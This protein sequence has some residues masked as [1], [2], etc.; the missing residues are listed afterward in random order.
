MGFQWRFPSEP[1]E[2]KAT[3]RPSQ[4]DPELRR[5]LE[6]LRQIR[7]K[8]QRLLQERRESLNTWFGPRS[9]KQLGLFFAGAGFLLCTVAI[10]RRAV[11]RKQLAAR[12]KFFAPSLYNK[13]QPRVD[14]KGKTTEQFDPEAE[15][16][17]IAAQA[18]GLATLNVF[19]FAVMMTGG[20]SWALD[21]SGMDD[22]R[23]LARRKIQLEDGEVDPNGEKEIEEWMSSMLL[24]NNDTNAQDTAT[25]GT[26]DSGA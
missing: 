20:L 9:I 2:G 15:G 3:S 14:A 17:L 12:P 23:V 11:V 25:D 18:L 1:A 8:E 24:P 4:D 10:T 19:S 16:G 21:I 6:Q 5:Q 26:S 7:E 22:L 13:P